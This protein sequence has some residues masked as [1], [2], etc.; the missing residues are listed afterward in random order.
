MGVAAGTATLTI[1]GPGGLDIH[2]AAGDAL[3]LPT[4]TGHRSI[5]ASDDFVVV[6]AYPRGQNWDI[7]RDAPDEEA[8]QRM[9]ALPIPEADPVAGKAGP[10]VELWT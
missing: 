4:G 6:G 9:G 10:L 8:R 1:G 5:E 3:V 7:R 2:V